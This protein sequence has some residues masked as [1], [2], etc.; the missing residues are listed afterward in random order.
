MGRVVEERSDFS[1]TCTHVNVPHNITYMYKCVHVYTIIG[2]EEIRICKPVQVT[3]L[4]N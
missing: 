2:I 4:Y 3:I 1:Y